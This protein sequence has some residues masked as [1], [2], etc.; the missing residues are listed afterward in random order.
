MDNESNKGFMIMLSESTCGHE[1]YVDFEKVDAQSQT[2]PPEKA[3][4]D[5]LLTLVLI[6]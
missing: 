2:L 3:F 5:I 4:G 6:N 1:R